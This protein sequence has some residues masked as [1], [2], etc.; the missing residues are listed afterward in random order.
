MHALCLKSSYD[1]YYTIHKI[2]K[3]YKKLRPF[4]TM[5]N[6]LYVSPLNNEVYTTENFA[7]SYF[8]FG[9]RY[10]SISD[11]E[12]YMTLTN[13]SNNFHMIYHQ[14]TSKQRY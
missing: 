1:A 8:Y 3:S 2:Y 7:T 10:M 9:Y 13:R 4:I 12:F 6:Y 11:I 14:S 5:L